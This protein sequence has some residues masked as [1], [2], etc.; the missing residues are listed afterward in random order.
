MFILAVDTALGRETCTILRDDRRIAFSGG[1]ENGLQAE[2]L[3][4]HLERILRE[5]GLEYSDIDYF[6][7]DLGPGSFTGIRIGLAAISAISQA[8]DKDIIGISSL[9]AL[10]FKHW[11]Q[12][13]ASEISVALDAGRSEVYFQRFN[14]DAGTAEEPELLAVENVNEADIGNMKFCKT[15][16]LPDAQDIGSYAFYL[17]ENNMADFFRKTPI[18]IRKPDA[19]LKA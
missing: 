16:A 5:T 17:I 3:F 13:G 8:L 14:M 18:Y 2:K 7:V 19:K 6:A 4:F 15:Q 1:E 9:E 11:Q 12:T 10:A